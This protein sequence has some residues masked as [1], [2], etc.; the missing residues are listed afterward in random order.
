MSCLFLSL[1][2]SMLPPR[3]GTN[4]CQVIIF[5]CKAK[6]KSI[7][8]VLPGTTVVGTECQLGKTRG[9]ERI[10]PTLRLEGFGS[11]AYNTPL[12]PI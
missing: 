12:N 7:M 1:F 4:I 9:K 5:V 10:Q 6:K 3:S 2:S 11:E 8:D